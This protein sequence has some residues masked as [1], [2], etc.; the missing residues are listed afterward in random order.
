[1]QRERPSNQCR[2]CGTEID[3]Y[4]ARVIGDN[5]GCI[6]VCPECHD[7]RHTPGD[8][9]PSLPMLVYSYRRR[10]DRA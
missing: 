7:G 2:S 8:K 4:V 5:D 1:M 3:P 10:Q 6:P 9:D